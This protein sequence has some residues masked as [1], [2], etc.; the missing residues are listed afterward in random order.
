MKRVLLLVCLIVSVVEFDWERYRIY[1][2]FS[3]ASLALVLHSELMGRRSVRG[4]SAE[5]ECDTKSRA[6]SGAHATDPPGLVDQAGQAG[7]PAS[8][9]ARAGALLHSN[10]G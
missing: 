5:K 10:P 9:T 7:N 2:L 4:T 3:I 8:G 6:S 1:L